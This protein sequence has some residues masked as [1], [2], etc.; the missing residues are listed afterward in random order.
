M[1]IWFLSDGLIFAE[2]KCC[3]IVCHVKRGCQQATLL[4]PGRHRSSPCLPMS[5]PYPMSLGGCRWVWTVLYYLCNHVNVTGITRHLLQAWSDISLVFIDSKVGR[6][7]PSLVCMPLYRW[8]PPI[9][10]ESGIWT[11]MSWRAILSWCRT[12]VPVTRYVFSVSTTE[13][14][15]WIFD[16]LIIC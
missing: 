1:Y 3:K 5:Y 4:L 16:L 7:G 14:K 10:H 6:W 13:F 2:Y 12:I 11:P 15:S 9:H 8:S